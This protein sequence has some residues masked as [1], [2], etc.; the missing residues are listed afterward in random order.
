MNG[1]I[2][3]EKPYC[4]E[5]GERILSLFLFNQPLRMDGHDQLLFQAIT[6]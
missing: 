1:G 5:G 6:G 2:T 4:R 3:T